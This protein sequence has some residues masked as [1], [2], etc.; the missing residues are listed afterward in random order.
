MVI[1]NLY[2]Q[3]FVKFDGGIE[4]LIKLI[5]EVTGGKLK[6]YSIDSAVLEID[7]VENDEF[8]QGS[9]DFLYWKFYLEIEPKINEEQDMY[10][11]SVCH[12]VLNFKKLGIAAVAACDFEDEIKSRTGVHW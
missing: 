1:N 8:V 3:L 10:V 6:L 11:D 2:C 9:E 5:L 12:L 7:V 4:K